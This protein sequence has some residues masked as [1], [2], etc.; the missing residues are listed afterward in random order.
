M[1]T[2]KLE[3]Y[4]YRLTNGEVKVK[5]YF[6]DYGDIVEAEDSEFVALVTEPYQADN[7]GAAMNKAAKLL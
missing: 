6:G 4:A 3:W 2:D 1:T 7:R 5:R